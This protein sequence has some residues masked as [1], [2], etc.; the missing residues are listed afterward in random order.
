MQIQRSFN[1]MAPS[2]EDDWSDSDEEVGSE[3][4]TPVLLGVPDG[5]ITSVGELAD[6]AVSRIGGHPVRAVLPMYQNNKIL[7]T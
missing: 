1:S 6:A 7:T 5:P 4:E 3:V 2:V